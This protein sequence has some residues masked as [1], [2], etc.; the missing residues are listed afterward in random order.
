M[1]NVKASEGI[2]PVDETSRGLSY[3]PLCHVYERMVNYVL[4]YKGVSVYYAENM[5]TIVDNIQEVHPHIM[6][7]VPRLL[8]KVYDKI[9]AKGRKLKGIKKATIFMLLTSV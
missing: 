7:T 9:L 4:Q 5:A 2:F 6:T 3:L 8:E 1:S